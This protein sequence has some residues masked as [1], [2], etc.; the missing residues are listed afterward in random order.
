MRLSHRQGHLCPV[1]DH[2]QAPWGLRKGGGYF[3]AYICVALGE[4]IP[5]LWMQGVGVPTRWMG[6]EGG[7]L[8][9]MRLMGS[10]LGYPTWLPPTHLGESCGN[11]S[12][13]GSR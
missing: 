1:P 7:G 3:R 8:K 11:H 2:D 9:K 10:P 5:H 13:A 12:P 4:G 6:S